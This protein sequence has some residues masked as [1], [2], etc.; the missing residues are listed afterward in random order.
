MNSTNYADLKPA[1]SL[2]RLNERLA[3]EV[4]AFEKATLLK[5]AS[6]KVKRDKEDDTLKSLES[7][8]R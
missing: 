6:I 3:E 8:V 5:L 7:H 1:D 2:M 4:E